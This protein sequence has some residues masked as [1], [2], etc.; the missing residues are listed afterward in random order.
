MNQQ[1]VLTLFK[2]WNLA[3][4]SGNAK[5]VSKLYANNAIFLPTLSNKV[6]CNRSEYEAYFMDFLTRSPQAALAESNIR[7]FSDTVIHS[8]IYDFT[9]KDSSQVKARFTFVYYKQNTDWLIVEHHSSFM[10]E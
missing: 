1:E 4:Q 9:F 10:P 5:T 3:L 6:R 7:I 2:R 8:G